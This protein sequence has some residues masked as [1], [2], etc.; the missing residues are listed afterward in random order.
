LLPACAGLLEPRVSRLELLKS[1]F[2]A[3]KHHMQVLLVYLQPF[4]RNSL[5]K[6]ALQPKIVKNSLKTSF[7]GIHGHSRSSM[8]IN[9]KSLWPVLVMISSMYLSATVFTLH[10][11]ITVKKPL[12]RGY[13]S[14]MPMCAGHLE[15]RES[16]LVLLQSTFN[17]ENFFGG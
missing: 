13:P 3:K 15:L 17:A 11:P 7:S 16:G 4:H 9:L 10:K 5:L 14:L 6:C 8:L 2:N 1:A 12:F